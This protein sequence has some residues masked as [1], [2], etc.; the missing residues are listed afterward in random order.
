MMQH[1]YHTQLCW[2]GN[3]GAGTL[4]YRAYS[5]DHE[6]TGEHKT[7]VIPGTSD[8][9][10]RGDPQR[11]N[12]EELL[13]H[14][15]SA[16]HMLWYLHLCAEHGVVVL[17]YKDAPSGSMQE[18]PQGHGGRFTAVT[19]RPQVQVAHP[20]MVPI[21]QAL[22]QAAHLHC[23]IANSCNFPIHHQPLVYLEE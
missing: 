20:D 17:A 18:N 23:F 15:L 19:L 14:S 8:P 3:R 6:M 22:H 16:C 5:R 10:F 12:P 4:D 2:T 11:Y 9:A 1:H 21:A 7:I 13:I